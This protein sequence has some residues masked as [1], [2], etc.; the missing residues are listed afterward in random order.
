MP[1]ANFF[2]AP[3]GNLVD[4]TGYAA[5]T[6]VTLFERH[7]LAKA[8]DLLASRP[9]ESLNASETI[10]LMLGLDNLKNKAAFRVTALEVEQTK[11]QVAEQNVP[12]AIL[13]ATTIGKATLD[14]GELPAGSASAITV[15]TGQVGILSTA[16]V[17]VF[18]AGE[19]TPE[20]TVDEAITENLRFHAFNIVP[21]TG[22]S[23]LGL[24]DVGRTWGTFTVNW[25]W[26]N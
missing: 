16:A 20:H 9:I 7:L 1:L 25:R 4:K 18:I 5:E 21:G 19:A 12:S 24:C 2:Q 23:I 14:F 11:T 10:A 3:S 8:V 6:H 17:D 26:K 15:I 22:F 13:A